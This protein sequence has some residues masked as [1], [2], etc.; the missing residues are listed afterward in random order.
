MSD[1]ESGYES[2]YGGGKKKGGIFGNP[3]VWGGIVAVLLIG[4]GVAAALL[5]FGDSS[6]E[7]AGNDTTKLVD[8]GFEN[9]GLVKIPDESTTST[10]QRPKT[11]KRT[12]KRTTTT[13]KVPRDCSDIK[14]QVGVFNIHPFE[15]VTK[16]VDAFC[17]FG[18]TIIQRRSDSGTSFRR[19]WYEYLEGFGDKSG[20]H[21]LGLR[22]IHAIL[23]ERNFVLRVELEKFDG[24]TAYAEYDGFYLDNE[25]E[26][27]AIH[28]GRYT[29]TAGNSL[30]YHVGMKFTTEDQDNDERN[31]NCATRYGGGGWWFKNCHKSNLNGEY[32]NPSKYNYKGLNWDHFNGGGSLKRAVMKVKRKF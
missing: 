7:M 29:G 24:Q 2:S 16:N 4:G 28:F 15:D 18:W 17:Q 26:K 23:K 30:A 14:Q 10:T 22:A 11:T 9:V 25:E 19:N 31:G 1:Y 3:L 5:L 21:W 8:S 27:F 13:V 6:V 20:N 12:T 32:Q